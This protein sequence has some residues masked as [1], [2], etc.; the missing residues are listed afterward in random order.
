[1]NSELVF[2]TETECVWVANM[3]VCCSRRKKSLLVLFRGC[4][5]DRE[6]AWL[7]KKYVVPEVFKQLETAEDGSI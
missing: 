6:S 3:T 5:R 1:M 7:T 4:L 2:I